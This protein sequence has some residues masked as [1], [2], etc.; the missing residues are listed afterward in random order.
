MCG[1]QPAEQRAERRP[2]ERGHK[3]HKCQQYGTGSQ[4]RYIPAEMRQNICLYGHNAVNVYLWVHK[5]EQKPG[6]KAAAGKVVLN[7]RAAAEGF[8]LQM[9]HI[10]PA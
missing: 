9:Q 2:A 7:I 4:S 8:P 1:K 10:Q 5:L 3:A 6:N